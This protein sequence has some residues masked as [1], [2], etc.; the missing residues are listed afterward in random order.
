[1]QQHCIQLLHQAWEKSESDDIDTWIKTMR[2]S[3][4]QFS[5][6]YAILELQCIILLFVQSIG[7]ANLAMLTNSLE[8]NYT[9]NICC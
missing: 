4:A 9:L 8:K 1:M 7:K 3:Y 2:S 5:H 6:G